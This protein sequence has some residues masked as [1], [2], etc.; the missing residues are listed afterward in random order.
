M[1]CAMKFP[2]KFETK[3]ETK[4]TDLRP[5]SFRRNHH[6]IPTD[7]LPTPSVTSVASCSK[8]NWQVQ[9]IGFTAQPFVC[10]R[11]H[12]RLKPSVLK[13]PTT[14]KHESTRI[15]CPL[16]VGVGIGIE[17]EKPKAGSPQRTQEAA[18]S[19]IR[20][21]LEF[22]GTHKNNRYSREFKPPANWQVQRPVCFHHEVTKDTKGKGIR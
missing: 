21:G 4:L 14:N 5:P 9:T 15:D 11:V 8:K 1:K 20:G 7:M 10:I 19:P 22:V 18:K 13:I 3:F 12:S 6:S 2:T 16:G 17:I